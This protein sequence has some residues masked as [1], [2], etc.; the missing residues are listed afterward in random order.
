MDFSQ[1]DGA[2]LLKELKA[3]N[4]LAL[5]EL[6]SRFS[7]FLKIEAYYR[8][9]DKQLAEE[10]VS[11]IF[12]SIWEKRHTLEI[13]VGWKPYLF[14]SIKNR[15][16]RIFKNRKLYKEAFK[17]PAELETEP[18]FDPAILENKELFNKIMLAISRISAPAGR[19]AF[20]MQYIDHK[21][22]KE[23]AREMNISLDAV[24]KQVS[25]GLEQVRHFLRK[26]S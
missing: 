13:K 15:C 12:I 25:R 20:K 7:K 23:I 19:K 10:A 9:R 18:G 8:L 14:A 6:V 1:A 26:N 22:Q 16:A 21:P 2:T 17:Y 24:K 4:E 11:D 3:G 5:K